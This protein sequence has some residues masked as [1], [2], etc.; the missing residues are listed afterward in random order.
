MEM[1]KKLTFCNFVM[2]LLVQLSGG[3]EELTFGNYGTF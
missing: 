3:I 2:I 1:G